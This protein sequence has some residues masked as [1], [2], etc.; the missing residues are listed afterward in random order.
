MGPSAPSS[1]I[2][3][4]S[5]WLD[6]SCPWFSFDFEYRRPKD[7]FGDS[8]VCVRSM[9]SCKSAALC[10]IAHIYLRSSLY[11]P[12]LYIDNIALSAYIPRGVPRGCIREMSPILPR[13]SLSWG[14]SARRGLLPLL[15]RQCSLFIWDL[16]YTQLRTGFRGL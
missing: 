14:C 10:S 5:S 12:F 3:S 8:V 15:F 9:F 7:V 1:L 2:A 6:P 13:K 4:L 11:F 16:L